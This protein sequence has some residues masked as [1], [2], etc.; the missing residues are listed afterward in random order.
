MRKCLLSAAFATA[1]FGLGIAA[2]PSAM[3]KSV[4]PSVE[5]PVQPVAC[6]GYRRNYRSF[7]HCWRVNGRIHPRNATYCSRICPNYGGK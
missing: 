5:S 4:G 2:A 3:P 1:F 7:N 6:V